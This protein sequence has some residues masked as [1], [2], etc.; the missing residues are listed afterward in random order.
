MISFQELLF[1]IEV[2]CV[3]R[4]KNAIFLQ[5][6]IVLYTKIRNLEDLIREY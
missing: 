4:T 6:K 3:V 2:L 1:G 5:N